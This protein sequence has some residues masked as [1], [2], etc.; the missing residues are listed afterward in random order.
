[1]NRLLGELILNGALS[2]P[3]G[4]EEPSQKVNEFSEAVQDMDD[5]TVKMKS[6]NEAAISV[7]I[8]TQP[9]AV[10]GRNTPLVR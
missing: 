3:S 7:V 9:K 2:A 4:S 8:Y 5:S 10:C 6:A 1:M